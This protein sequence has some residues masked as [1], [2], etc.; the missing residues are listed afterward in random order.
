ME[1]FK[2][3]A[4]LYIR[5]T[6]K[7]AKQ[8]AERIRE[9]G[10]FSAVYLVDLSSLGRAVSA[11]LLYGKDKWARLIRSMDYKRVVAFNIESELLSALYNKN[12]NIKDFQYHYVEDAP[13][14][15]KMYAPKRYPQVSLNGILGI[16]QPYYHTDQWWFSDPDFMDIP[17]VELRT[18]KK[19]PPVDIYDDIF[20]GLINKVFSFTPDAALNEADIF[21]TE[22]SF[23]TD[24][25]MLDNCD[26]ILY[27]EIKDYFPDRNIVI[28]LHPRTKH[29][30][31]VADFKIM[32]G[33]WVPW[34][35]HVMNGLRQ[36]QHFPIQIGIVCS[37]LTSDKFMFNVESP[38]IVLAPLFREK[39]RSMA[40]GSSN[41]DEEVI[42]KFEAL[43]KTYIRSEQMMI[44]YEKEQLFD[45]LE[46]W[47]DMKV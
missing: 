25:K 28:K 10:L 43:R 7:N 46:K 2:D 9:T 18:V 44:T 24:G 4:D 14:M 6:F 1:E 39:I 27:K 41:V 11:R 38:K 32:D 34:E 20:I 22:E 8:I 3:P 31:F 16:E 35:L 30:R 23:Y 40:D 47:F 19:L 36:K 12:K 15:Y 5:P 42:K 21:I 45:T 37:A 13:G 33:T 29:N 26:Y 17:N